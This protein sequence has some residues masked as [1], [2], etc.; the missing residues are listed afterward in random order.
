MFG[1]VKKVL[2]IDK[3]EVLSLALLYVLL[4]SFKKLYVITLSDK[5]LVYYNTEHNCLIML[6]NEVS[7][8]G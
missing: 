4:E 1:K 2:N 3:L 5:A 6:V 8:M 7:H